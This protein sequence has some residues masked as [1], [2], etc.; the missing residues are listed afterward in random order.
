LQRNSSEEISTAAGAP[1]T[2]RIGGAAASSV[3]E[4]TVSK[5]KRTGKRTRPFFI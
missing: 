1:A 3:T 2:A 4:T 5:A